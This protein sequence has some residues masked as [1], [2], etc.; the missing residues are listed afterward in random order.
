[1]LISKWHHIII[2]EFIF[3]LHAYMLDVNLNNIYIYLTYQ[4]IRREGKITR[5]NF[6][7]NNIHK[8]KQKLLLSL[9]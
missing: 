3:V 2:F 9:L 1:M 8:T 4:M 5:G 6:F 7:S